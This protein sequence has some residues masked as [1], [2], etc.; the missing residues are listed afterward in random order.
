[1][2]GSGS[3]GNLECLKIACEAEP[4]SVPA[5]AFVFAAAQGFLPGVLYLQTLR[6]S[7]LWGEGEPIDAEGLC[8]LQ[9]SFLSY[10]LDPAAPVDED[11]GRDMLHPLNCTWETVAKASRSAGVGLRTP[12]ALGI[13]DG[14]S[15]WEVEVGLRTF[16]RMHSRVTVCVPWEACLKLNTDRTTYGNLGMYGDFSRNIP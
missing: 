11:Y 1:M 5:S 8:N 4:H 3:E 2:G 9:N 7:A 15:T 13:P 6:D 12:L 14:G 16:W 10:L